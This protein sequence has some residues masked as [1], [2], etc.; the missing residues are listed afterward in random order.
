MTNS[1]IKRISLLAEK[2]TG[3]TFEGKRKSFFIS[4]IQKRL[5]QVGISEIEEYFKLIHKDRNEQT[6]FVDLF[7][8]HETYF[9]R[10]KHLWD[11][12]ALELNALPQSS[13][14]LRVWCAASSTGEEVY[15][16]AM[17]LTEHQHHN[18]Q[19]KFSILAS[20]ISEP[21]LSIAKE[22]VYRG[23]SKNSLESYSQF[24]KQN[25][26]HDTDDDSMKARALLK[27]NV[28]FIRHDLLS[29]KR[30]S[31]EFDFIFLR[32]VLIYFTIDKIDKILDTLSLNLKDAGHL[33]IGE[34]ESLLHTKKF[35]YQNPCFYKKAV[36][37]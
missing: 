17:M 2:L 6:A 15:S 1:E 30:I 3:N 35:V 14:P 18:P 8:T 19:F 23:R 4:R 26:F 33:I 37:T 13:E 10:T 7:T 27:K 11:R 16:I 32:N 9:F 12:F 24:L 36:A 20:D 29:T 34:S 31:G 5:S 28:Q 25:Y 21:S 22:A